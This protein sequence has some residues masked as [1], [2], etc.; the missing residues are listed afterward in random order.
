MSWA[1]RMPQLLAASIHADLDRPHDVA[2]ERVG[3]IACRVTRGRD[4]RA[5]LAYAYLPVEDTHYLPSD[6][7]G[8]LINAD[9]IRAAMQVAFRDKCAIVH[10]HRHD[11][12]G[13]PGFSHVDRTENAKLIPTFWNVSGRMP[14]G[15]MVLSLDRAYGEVWDPTDRQA[16]EFTRISSVGT[17]LE[18]L[19]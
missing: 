13:V 8:A 19:S 5:L 3:F 15:A 16:C 7:M 14:H 1:L 12:P 17:R 6:E 10:V 9:A 11:H 4:T 18:E 2:H